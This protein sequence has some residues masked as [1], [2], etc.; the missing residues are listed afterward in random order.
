MW[1]KSVINCGQFLNIINS[2]NSKFLPQSTKYHEQKVTIG[3]VN[4]KGFDL[5]C[6]SLGFERMIVN[7]EQLKMDDSRLDLHKVAACFSC[8]LFPPKYILSASNSAFSFWEYLKIA[9]IFSMALEIFSLRR[10][11][12]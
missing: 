2:K 10:Q 1:G 4:G 8:L 6:V 7:F 11:D 3:T 12:Q 9:F 5:A